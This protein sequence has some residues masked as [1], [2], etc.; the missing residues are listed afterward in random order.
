MKCLSD[1]W[2]HR[3]G[4][5]AFLGTLV[6]L[7]R[8]TYRHFGSADWFSAYLIYI[9]R[10]KEFLWLWKP[11][12][13][14]FNHKVT[15]VAELT[16]LPL[17]TSVWETGGHRFPLVITR[18]HSMKEMMAGWTAAMDCPGRPNLIPCPHIFSH[19]KM[20]VHRAQQL[21]SWPLLAKLKG[22]AHNTPARSRSKLPLFVAGTGIREGST[23]VK[24]LV[25]VLPKACCHL[26]VVLSLLCHGIWI[27]SMRP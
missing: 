3:T 5:R 11:H 27:K 6:K 20:Y 25:G 19:L 26:Q 8:N 2:F 16:C 23:D 1:C 9:Q 22:R 7:H 14:L 17:L 21:L 24:V 18:K 12:E 15:W 10:F 4:M 13:T